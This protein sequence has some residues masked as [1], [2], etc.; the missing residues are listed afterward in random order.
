MLSGEA[1]KHTNF[2]SLWF[3]PGLGTHDLALVLPYLGLN[4]RSSVL[5]ASTLTITPPM[6]LL[7]KIHWSFSGF[8]SS[9]RLWQDFLQHFL[10][11]VINVK[12]Y[13]ALVSLDGYKSKDTSIKQINLVEE[14]WCL[15]SDTS[16]YFPNF[17]IFSMSSYVYAASDVVGGI[18]L[19]H[20][21]PIYFYSYELN[22][23]P[24]P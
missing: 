10:K 8:I 4:T 19:K 5:E 14:L 23:V 13:D 16:S 6:R 1:A 15:V 18:Q 21:L 9:I 17:C 7:R 2:I 22:H 24:F 3:Y 20:L 11:C 12:L